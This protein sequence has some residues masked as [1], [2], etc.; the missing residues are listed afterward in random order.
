MAKAQPGK[1][2]APKME[3]ISLT[4]RLNGKL[5]AI[6][7]SNDS[8]KV[9]SRSSKLKSTDSIAARRSSTA[10]SDAQCINGELHIQVCLGSECHWINT[11]IA[12]S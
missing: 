9:P 10:G 5:H 7:V 4:F 1:P 8:V 3:L 6:A 11:H 12:C 2:K